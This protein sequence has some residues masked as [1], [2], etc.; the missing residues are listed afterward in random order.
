MEDKSS[1]VIDRNSS[2]PN[3]PKEILSASNSNHENRSQAESQALN[4]LTD[5]KSSKQSEKPRNS[6]KPKQSKRLT[7]AEKNK[8]KRIKTYLLF[9]IYLLIPTICLILSHFLIYDEL[10]ELHDNNKTSLLII[11]IFAIVI[12]LV[13]SVIV[14]F[15]ECFQKIPFINW[16][17][18][19]ALV[20][21]TT[22]TVVYIGVF[23]YFEQMYCSMI[24]LVGGSFGL[25]LLITVS[26]NGTNSIF[27]LLVFN[28]FCSA[29]A[30]I[31]M[32][33]IYRDNLL[34]TIV[35]SS[36]AF[37]VSEFNIYT[38]Q[39]KLS[40]KKSKKPPEIISQPFEFVI[41]LFKVIYI[42][43]KFLWT[44]IKKCLKT[45]KKTEN[46]NQEPLHGNNGNNEQE[47]E[48]ENNEEGNENANEGGNEENNN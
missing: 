16:I 6:T 35:F 5:R 38:S 41:S 1:N 37:L 4:V 17:L 31:I 19:I 23:F 26:A 8:F 25:F 24:V 13:L 9:F 20:I 44:I 2:D 36:V 40:E 43:I 14:T 18:Y 27:I 12:S 34:W 29:I 32:C 28:T 47:Q 15:L 22:Y 46:E 39:T 21:C 30:G 48:G 45:C 3:S 10:K 11:F 33:Y 7:I 42:V